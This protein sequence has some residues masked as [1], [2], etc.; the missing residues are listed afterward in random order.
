MV[1]EVLNEGAILTGVVEEG[2]EGLAILKGS[3][4]DTS[5]CSLCFKRVKSENDAG[6]EIVSH[7]IL[8]F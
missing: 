2:N 6:S 7:S 4:W 5:W 3:S 8:K 1:G